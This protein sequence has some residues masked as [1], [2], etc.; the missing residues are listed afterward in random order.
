MST[1]GYTWRHLHTDK[2]AK[3]DFA[4]LYNVSREAEQGVTEW[5]GAYEHDHVRISMPIGQE[6]WG[7][8]HTT[9]EKDTPTARKPKIR[10]KDLTP[11]I[12]QLNIDLAPK[13][14][15]I[16]RH[17]AAHTINEKQG[18]EEMCNNRIAAVEKLLPRGGGE[19]RRGIRSP[20]RDPTQ[21]EAHR[22]IRTL[23][24]ALQD[25][26][27]NPPTTTTNH[28]MTLLGL[29]EELQLT[30]NDIA[31]HARGPAWTDAIHSRIV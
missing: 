21:R 20:H 6:L 14:V 8:P 4:V 5:T 26:P 1:Q 12:E 30:P 17:L 16:L 24:M 15:D 19:D 22:E 29:T 25:P 11:H 3:L 9:E 28:T 10:Q 18:K 31:Y 23:T 13:T 2:T 7:P 27:S